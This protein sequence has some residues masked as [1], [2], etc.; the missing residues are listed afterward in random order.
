MCSASTETIGCRL[1]TWRSAANAPERISDQLMMAG[2]F[3]S[4]NGVLGCAAQR[5]RTADVKAPGAQCAN[6]RVDRWRFDADVHV[7]GART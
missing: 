6:E 7:R 5:D 3:V 2:A 4:C 1:T